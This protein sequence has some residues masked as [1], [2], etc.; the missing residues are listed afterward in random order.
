[1]P[2]FSYANSQKTFSFNP[3]LPV[4]RC[5]SAS[6]AVVRPSALRDI[7][8]VALAFPP[9]QTPLSQ[10]ALDLVAFAARHVG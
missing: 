2:T 6:I 5:F 8:V 1:M 3:Q 4:K 7:N 9:P 10:P